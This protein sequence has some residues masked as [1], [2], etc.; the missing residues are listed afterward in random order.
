MQRFRIDRRKR[1][2]IIEVVAIISIFVLIAVDQ[3]TK[4]AIVDAHLTSNLP[5]TIIDNFFKIIYAEN[6]GAAFSFLSD[7]SWASTFFMILTPIA[8]VIFG[9]IYFFMRKKSY[10]LRIGL[11]L[12]IA[13]TVGNFIDRI[14]RGFVVDFLSFTFG[15]LGTFATFNI[16][17]A[18]LCVGVIMLLIYFLFLDSDAIFRFKK[19]NNNDN[20]DNKTIENNGENNDN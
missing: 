11:I 3:L 20:K 7:A 5:K 9:V 19:K 4:L 16:A 13:G 15:D 8:L 10:W 18:F 17:D 6:R 2:I 14:F 12:I 1:Q